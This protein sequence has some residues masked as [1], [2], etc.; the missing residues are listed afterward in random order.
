MLNPLNR[1][2]IVTWWTFLVPHTWN[3]RFGIISIIFLHPL[4]GVALNHQIVTLVWCSFGHFLFFSNLYIQ[5]VECW[6]QSYF[7]FFLPGRVVTKKIIK[8]NFFSFPSKTRLV[9][10]LEKKFSGKH[11][12]IVAQVSTLDKE[13]HSIYDTTKT[14][15]SCNHLLKTTLIVNK[16]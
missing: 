13:D 11:V 6:C 3:R 9:R 5:I 15:E 16:V 12:V 4:R 8:I 10:E 1:N 7:A 2:N 14:S